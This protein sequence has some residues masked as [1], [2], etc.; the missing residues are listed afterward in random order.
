MKT[1]FE[2]KVEEWWN[3][4]SYE[5][6]DL[7]DDKFFKDD[8]DGINTLERVIQCYNSLTKEEMLDLYGVQKK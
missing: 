7:L 3:A 8:K 1:E 5:R 6:Q 4:L 2:K